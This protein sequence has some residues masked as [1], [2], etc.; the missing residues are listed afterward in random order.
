MKSK[1]ILTIGLLAVVIGIATTGIA[2]QSVQAGGD[3]SNGGIGVNPA[4]LAIMKAANRATANS[5]RQTSQQIT[6]NP[7]LP[8]VA[9]NIISDKLGNAA[10]QLDPLPPGGCFPPQ[11]INQN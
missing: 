2:I 5:L 7:D 8:N 10:N 3:G 9:K 6:S 11:C 1:F 4:A